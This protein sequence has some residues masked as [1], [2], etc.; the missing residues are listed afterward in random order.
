MRRFRAGAVVFVA[1]CIAAIALGVYFAAVFP[2]RSNPQGP[3]LYLIMALGAAGAA[4]AL[5]CLVTGVRTMRDPRR[6]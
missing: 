2:L 5:L 4:G 1:A 3:G 6:R